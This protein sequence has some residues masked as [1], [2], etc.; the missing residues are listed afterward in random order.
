MISPQVIGY[1]CLIAGASMVAG[2]WLAF[3]NRTYLLSLGIFFLALAASL[4]IWGR[5]S[6][7]PITARV[8]WS[9]RCTVGAAAI[10]F[11]MS[12]AQAVKETRQ[13]LREVRE[14]YRAA[15]Q[16]L[17]D[18]TQ[19]KERQLRQSQQQTDDASQDTPPRDELG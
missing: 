19:A 3:R 9:L 13:R 6:T 7:G 4:I 16:A 15:A 2:W 1:Y 5:A 18:V 17:T 8:L 10:A 14:H 11:V 12:V